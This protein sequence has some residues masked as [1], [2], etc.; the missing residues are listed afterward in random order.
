MKIQLSIP[1]SIAKT[2]YERA[3]FK[4]W[5]K[6]NL[7][8]KLLDRLLDK[9]KVISIQ[10][11]LRKT[12]KHTSAHIGIK[13]GAANFQ[14]V[15]KDR[16]AYFATSQALKS[17]KR[18]CAENIKFTPKNVTKIYHVDSLLSLQQKSA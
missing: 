5:F 2:S 6:D 1:S 14:V 10:L 9:S 15:K 7:E 13:Y 3:E 18:I 11:S 12:G 8:S 16:D 4:D 17:L